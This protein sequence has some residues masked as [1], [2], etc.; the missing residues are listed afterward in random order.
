MK[1][2]LLVVLIFLAGCKDVTPTNP[3]P[4]P[5]ATPCQCESP[6]PCQVATAT[7][8]PTATPWACNLP[9]MPNCA[10]N[11]PNCCKEGGVNNYKDQIIESQ[12]KLRQAKPE[13]FNPNGSI[14]VSDAEYTT[15][16]AKVLQDTFKIC[17]VG[18]AKEPLSKDEIG[19]KESNGSAIH[20]DV[21][22]GSN[23]L[24]WVG[25]VYTCSPAAF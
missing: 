13:M 17:A 2:K 6:T 4:T 16:L 5:T 21:V 23:N 12:L 3:S 10:K 19:I 15:E 11:T 1:T 24:P 18:G 14:K 22:I 25:I 9:K 20:V 7:P 8:V